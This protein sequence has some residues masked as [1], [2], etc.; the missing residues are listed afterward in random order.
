[1]LAQTNTLKPPIGLRLPLWQPPPYPAPRTLQGRYVR[2]E[3]LDVDKHAQG[4]FDALT[5]DA[6]GLGWTYLPYGP[7]ESFPDYLDWLRSVGSKRDPL[8]FTLFASGSNQ[9]SGVAS[10][11]RIDPAN[12]SIEVGH[13][14]YGPSLQRSVAATE[15]MVLMMQ[16]AFQLGYRRYEWKCNALNH[17]S[18]TAAQRLGFSFEGL[19][20]QA[21]VV[22]GHNR[23]TAWFSVI[24][25]DWPHLEEIFQRWLAPD[26]FD[27]NG[28]QKMALST[29]T[30]PVLQNTVTE[31]LSA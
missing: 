12:G 13:I 2:L 31:L 10:Y 18:R 17:P 5:S 21:A 1:M 20:R 9:P 7:F 16:H 6:S 29:L 15:A 19:F 27:E 22:K 4:L 28:R 3:P 11:L 26:N 8:F 30:R 23:D 14:H 24:D 25:S